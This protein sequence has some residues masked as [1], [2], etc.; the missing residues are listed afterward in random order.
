MKTVTSAQNPTLKLVRKLM[1]SGRERQR[2]NKILLD[3]PHLV[4]DYVSR[5]GLS[6]CVAIFDESAVAR[7]SEI[8]DLVETMANDASILLVP[9]KTFR[10]LS[11]VDTPSGVVAICERPD[12]GE[13]E[14]RICAH[15]LLDGIQNPGNLGSILRT[16]A[17]T[18]VT[19]VLLSPTCTDAWSPK[20]LRGGMG[21]QFVLP[22]SV[23][24]DAVAALRAFQGRRVATSSHH[25]QILMEADLSGPVLLLFGGEGAG[26]PANLI[27]GAD[28]TVRIPLDNALESLNIGAAVAM[29]C[30]ER[31]R[32]ARY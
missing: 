11:P 2:S 31:M 5:F 19:R 30:Y 14:N 20:C 23:V 4:S 7:S 16:A 28:L 8:R 21:A 29:V 10:S 32:Q 6:G 1:Q 9:E 15:L 3:G 25:G 17:A 18:G 12:V 22:I 27:D 13:A 26:L 24:P